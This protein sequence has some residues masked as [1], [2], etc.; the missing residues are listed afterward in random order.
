MFAAVPER[1]RKKRTAAV[2]AIK[3]FGLLDAD[4]G[5]PASSRSRLY[6]ADHYEEYDDDADGDEEY[7]DDADGDEE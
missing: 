4:D 3:G 5:A 1:G 2:A 6:A 7:N